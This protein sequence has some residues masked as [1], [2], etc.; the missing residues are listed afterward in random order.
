M[1]KKIKPNKYIEENVPALPYG[2]EKELKNKLKKI[3]DEIEYS[4]K[5]NAYNRDLSEYHLN[6]RNVFIEMFVQMF[7][8]IDKY[9][10]FLDDDVVFNKN[11]FMETVPKEDK[12]FYDEFIDTQLFQL[13]TQNFV[14]DELDYFKSMKDEFNKNNQFSN[15][16][17]E[18]IRKYIKK[19]YILN[20]DYLGI[21]ENNKRDIEMKVKDEYN[22]KK[23]VDM[24]GF[25]V[26]DKRITEYIQNIDNDNY[27]NKNCNIYLIPEK[28]EK[29]E[30]PLGLLSDLLTKKESEEIGTNNEV[31]KFARVKTRKFDLS[32]KDK[33]W[34][35]EKIRDFAIKIFKSEEIKEDSHLKKDLQNDINTTF[36]REY[37]V[38]L[39]ARNVSNVI[40]LKASS[41]NL[42]GTLIYNTLLYILQVEENDKI[43]E[44]IVV[45]I[46][47]TMFF[48]KEEIETI[49][50][51]L[52]EEKKNTITLWEI[53][54][55][56]IQRYPKVNQANLWN[57]W[58][59]I[60]LNAERGKENKEVKI[61][62]I[63]KICD[64]MIELELIKS[65]IKNTL[66]KL[67]KK[68]FGGNEENNKKILQQIVQKIIHAKYISKAKK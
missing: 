40:L 33:E 14:N 55:K 57:K 7:H 24:D 3:K 68:T 44:Q 2:L 4:Q 27:N 22:L 54:K 34:I 35:K 59:E 18:D 66:D 38:F 52:T 9:L 48:A 39:L 46:K 29:L 49:G 60:N 42:L 15:D 23:E 51:F 45:L 6:I 36:G 1:E 53:Y 56:K 67:I 32:E 63:L 12:K 28:E 31:K 30:Q 11:L 5:K 21:K 17:N 26:N 10:C 64:L 50:Y 37:F 47:S 25:I 58:Y 13:F 65:F 20:P 61:K 16:K 41:F 43:L 19:I 62:V 8:E